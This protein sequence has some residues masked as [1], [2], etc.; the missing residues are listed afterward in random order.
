V[1]NASGGTLNFQG[2][3]KTALVPNTGDGAI[4]FLENS[5]A[6]NGNFINEGAL[7]SGNAPPILFLGSSTAGNASLTNEGGAATGAAGG[8][9][10]FTENST[11]G[12][13]TLISNGSLVNDA[14]GSHIIFFG[15]STAGNATI[16]LNGGVGTGDSGAG[17]ELL[18]DSSGGL[19]RLQVF[20]NARLEISAH[21]PALITLGSIEGNGSIFLGAM[22]LEVGV[23]NLSTEFFGTIAEGG[24]GGG[25][26]GTL[27]KE[28]TGTLTLSGPNSYTGGTAI[29]DGALIVT[30]RNASPTGTGDVSVNQG[31]LGGE[32]RL[33]GAIVVGTGGGTGA[34]LAPGVNGI[35]ALATA[36][37]LRFGGNST[38]LCE[39]DPKRRRSDSVAAHGV[40]IL[41]DS[42]FSLINLRQRRLPLG[43]TFIV[44]KNASADAI[45]GT[46]SNLADQSTITAG[47]NTFQ[48]NYEGG[49]GNDLT[50]TVVP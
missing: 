2:T 42:T 12:E 23:N 49:D 50:L 48:A 11:A 7:F 14:F 3:N 27:F 33:S 24:E 29:D 37:T 6:G 39:L 47:G 9:I 40:T 38:Y 13:A 16:V 25:V 31:T 8:V 44:I 19:A 26:G 22:F 18:E 17:M 15:T 20:G 1:N 4:E 21:N 5:S 43:T 41:N 36:K 32:S 45:S 28:G 46:F 30:T 35:G 34:F 10:D